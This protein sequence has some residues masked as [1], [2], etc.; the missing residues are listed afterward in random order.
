MKQVGR[1][2]GGVLLV[3]PDGFVTWRNAIAVDDPA[4]ALDCDLG[5][6]LDR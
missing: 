4:G 3:R 5:V 1:P 2:R 6:V